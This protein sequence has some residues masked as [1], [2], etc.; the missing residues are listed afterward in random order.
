MS[1]AH[2][3]VVSSASLPASAT[4]AS[5]LAR[6][7]PLLA[8]APGLWAL[9]GRPILPVDELRYLTVAWEMW[10]RGDFL[11]PYLNGAPYSHKPPLLFWLVHSGWAVFGV[12]EWWPRLVGPLCATLAATLIARLA[13]ELWPVDATPARLV[14][15]LL[16]GSIGWSM[17]GGMVM[18]DALLACAVLVAIIGLARASY[19]GRPAGFVL[20]AAGTGL[21]LLAKGPVTLVHVLVPGLFAPWWSESARAR[22]LRWYGLLLL[23]GWAGLMITAAWALPAAASGG[24][25]YAEAILWRQTAGRMEHSFAHARPWY[26][27]AVF[28]PLLLLPWVAWPPLWRGARSLQ[29]S[30]RG[31]RFVLAWALSGTV[32]LSLISAKQ[33][34]YLMPEIAAFCMLIAA[35]ARSAGN[36]RSP[37]RLACATVA[38]LLGGATLFFQLKGSAYDLHAPAAAVARL[39]SSGEDV[40]VFRR[41]H[42]QLGFIGRLAKP[43]RTVPSNEANAWAAAHPGAILLTFADAP[44]A[45]VSLDRIAT[46]PYR[47]RRVDI[48]RI[49]PSDD[50]V[51]SR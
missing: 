40:Y 5:W 15:W 27:Y 12:N 9:V 39:Q 34:H 21:G 32:A 44:P 43:L 31:T 38:L 33:P 18:F 17:L 20:V 6:A 7:W 11:V 10:T 42:G 29:V 37:L 4:A 2:C 13:R 45:G 49:L 1:D 28:L 46:Y 8:L 47:T 36:I 51:P 50:R 48:W 35:A 14:P 22:P 30:D 25:G 41:Y 23:A 19:T 26:E 16:A 24:P 3:T